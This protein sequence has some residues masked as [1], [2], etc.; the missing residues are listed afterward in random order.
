MSEKKT[1]APG[2]EEVRYFD[3]QISK[4]FAELRTIS[5]K[6]R[7]AAIA[8]SQAIDEPANDPVSLVDIITD[9]AE[10]LNTQLDDIEK[11]LHQYA[12]LKQ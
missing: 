12:T 6:I 8:A 4:D 11:E 7:A 2:A 10:A 9:Y 3:N 5:L 1:T